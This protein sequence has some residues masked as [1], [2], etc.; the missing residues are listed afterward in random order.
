MVGFERDRTFARIYFTYA[1]LDDHRVR[2]FDCRARGRCSLY[3]PRSFL[4]SNC[5]VGGRGHWICCSFVAG[6]PSAR[7]AGSCAIAT[8]AESVR[9]RVC[10]GRTLRRKF[11]FEREKRGVQRTRRHRMLWCERSNFAGCDAQVSGCL[12]PVIAP[13]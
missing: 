4:Q 6:P 8:L 3:E 1:S 2:S 10:I 9:Y 13:H 11:S 7:S 12:R 5:C